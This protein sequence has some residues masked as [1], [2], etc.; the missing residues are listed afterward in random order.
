[1]P[2]NDELSIIFPRIWGCKIFIVFC[3]YQRNCECYGNEEKYNGV[4]FLIPQSEISEATKCFEVAD[5]FDMRS[6]SEN[7][8][9]KVE[10]MY[11]GV[12]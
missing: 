4:H 6:I 12:G 2:D 9:E 3:N 8:G 1:M 5:N 7:R 10:Q 11:R